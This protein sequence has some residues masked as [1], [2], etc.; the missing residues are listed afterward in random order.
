M[1]GSSTF[2]LIGTCV[3]Q[4]FPDCICPPTFKCSGHGYCA[5]DENFKPFC[6]CDLH[7]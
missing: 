5:S 7:W 2:V 3:V 6:Q 1:N 4:Y